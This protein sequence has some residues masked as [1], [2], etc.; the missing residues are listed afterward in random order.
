[1][2]ADEP[3]PLAPVTAI[4]AAEWDEVSPA[5]NPTA[6]DF[7]EG[8]RT[9]VPRLVGFLRYQGVPLAD[10]AD[11][12]QETMI[13]AYPQWNRITHHEAWARRV[14]SRVWAR[15]LARLEFVP[16]SGLSEATPLLRIDGDIA[17]WEQRH[18]VI[19]ILD[20]LPSRQ[21][22]VL[23]WTL[24]GHSPREIAAELKMTP[25]AVRSSLKLAR[26]AVAALLT[27]GANDD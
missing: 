27:S 13:S 10:A 14:A 22:Q 20:Q 17:E 25:E 3:E 5:E 4:P 6:I 18:D 21:R 19:A 23:A 12:V 15:R 11:V 1:M 7:V 8:Y 26:R 9:I 24:D 2:T 16:T